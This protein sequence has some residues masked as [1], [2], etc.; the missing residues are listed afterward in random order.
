MILEVEDSIK[1]LTDRSNAFRSGKRGTR[2]SQALG[3]VML[4]L[5]L[6]NMKIS[7]LLPQLPARDEML[8]DT[9]K[10]E[11]RDLA[12]I[13]HTSALFQNYSPFALKS[14]I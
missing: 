8:A 14:S 4:A 7:A 13:E 5:A 11:N 10:I 9:N 6:A 1:T 12:T 2:H 3:T